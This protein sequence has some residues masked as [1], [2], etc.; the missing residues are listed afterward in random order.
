MI[1]YKKLVRTDI[2]HL[3]DKVWDEH[4]VVLGDNNGYR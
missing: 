2:L 4:G 3:Q 1:S